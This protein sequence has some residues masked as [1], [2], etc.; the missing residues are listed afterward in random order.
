VVGLGELSLDHLATLAYLPK[1]GDKLE[2]HA[3]RDLP[4]GQVATAVLG[5]RRLGLRCGIVGC[6]GEDEAGD[7]ALAPLEL[8]GVETQGVRRRSTARTR[9]AAIL[10]E[11]K[12]GERTIIWQRDPRLDLKIGEVRREEI[13]AGQVLL[14]DAG[15]PDLALWAARI[16]RE[17]DRATILDVDAP[18]PGVEALLAAVDFPIVPQEFL[19]VA[20]G[21]EAPQRGLRTLARLGARFPVVTL[22][23]RGAVG[24]SPETPLWSPAFPV[25]VVDTTGAGDA[26]HAGFAWG[27]LQGLR[28]AD[29]LRA[30]NATAGLNCRALGAQAGL[31]TREELEALLYVEAPGQAGRRTP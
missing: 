11:R 26:F 24:G 10:V 13:E 2:A 23:S 20:F 16:A 29:L 8:A 21:D 15:D 6:V 27:L 31:P 14:L 7:V 18:G 22:G 9:S 25:A 4:G 19:A 1:P 12:T 28:P 17:A 3:W 30:G 5:C